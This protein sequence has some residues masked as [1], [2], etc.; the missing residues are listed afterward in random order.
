M[1]RAFQ[2]IQSQGAPPSKWNPRK[3]KQGPQTR[4][5]RLE[6]RSRKSVGG[7]VIQ[8]PTT[9]FDTPA[10]SMHHRLTRP[11]S[12]IYIHIYIYK[13]NMAQPHTYLQTQSLH[14]RPATN[15]FPTVEMKPP[16]A[17]AGTQNTVK[18][19]RNKVQE[20]ARRHGHLETLQHGLTHPPEACT[21]ESHGQSHSYTTWPGHSRIS[22]HNRCTLH[23][24][25]AT[26]MFPTVE[27]KPP[28]AQAGT[29]NT[30]KMTRNKVQEEPRRHGHPE[31][32]GLKHAPHSHT[33]TASMSA[34]KTY[35]PAAPHGRN[36][37]HMTHLLQKNPNQRN[38]SNISH[39]KNTTHAQNMPKKTQ[40]SRKK[41]L[42]HSPSKR[43]HLERKGS[44]FQS[45]GPIQGRFLQ[46]FF[47]GVYTL[48]E[49]KKLSWKKWM[50]GRWW[51]PFLGW[52]MEFRY[53]S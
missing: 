31:S 40:H 38:N 42:P 41:T 8:N 46:F 20:E 33:H 6:S 11:E 24:R 27:M 37:T 23:T 39:P 35:R 34:Y 9:W 45:S 7:T 36:E 43:D 13:Y 17:Q 3:T 30:D 12:L 2:T 52:P 21:I 48:P 18:M 10:W 51:F 53:Q 22:R 47:W 25:P 29:Q 16:K 44:F 4:S 26:N 32:L 28:K 5:K 1:R 50:V 15:M 49:T 14:T 19:T